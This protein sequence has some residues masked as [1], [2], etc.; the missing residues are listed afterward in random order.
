MFVDVF[1]WSN[2]KNVNFICFQISHKHNE[3]LNM[4]VWLHAILSSVV[5]IIENV[6]P[7]NSDGRWHLYLR[8]MY[9]SVC[10]QIR[11]AAVLSWSDLMETSCIQCIFDQLLKEGQNSSQLPSVK[12][13]TMKA[14]KAGNYVNLKI[15]HRS[16]MWKTSKHPSSDHVLCSSCPTADT[17]LVNIE[18]VCTEE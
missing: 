10:L 6:S 3:L 15:T 9:W 18:A 17:L 16:L 14:Y 2:R 5:I 11:S 4:W 8:Q 1:H 12:C 13:S 7:T